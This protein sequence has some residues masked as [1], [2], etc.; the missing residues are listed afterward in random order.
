[1]TV[2]EP[3]TN[4]NSIA[5]FCIPVWAQ[6]TEARPIYGYRYKFYGPCNIEYLEGTFLVCGTQVWKLIKFTLDLSNCLAAY[7]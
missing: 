1:M 5:L 7:L 4:C 6:A 2:L 3:P